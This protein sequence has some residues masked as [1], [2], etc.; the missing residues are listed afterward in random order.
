M[1]CKIISALNLKGGSG[2]TSL[3]INLAGVL[4]ELKFSPL[5]IDLDPQKSSTMWARQGGSKFNIPIY[6][7]DLSKGAGQFKNLLDSLILKERASH[8]LIDL[9]PQ[10]AEEAFV[11]ALISDLV[12]IPISPSPLDLW[13]AKEA[14]KMIRDARIERKGA[15]PLASLVPSKLIS[16]TRLAKD[17]QNTLKALEEP[18]SPPIYQRVAVPE[19]ALVGQTISNYAR[20]SASHK[21]YMSLGKYVLNKM[22][23]QINV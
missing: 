18:I 9:P 14:V 2:K 13:A 12:L 15:F 23:K 22:L 1:P 16:S 3:I 20:G 10:L 21:E 5:I 7:G 11:A 17:I 6:E 19:A 4:K 8:V